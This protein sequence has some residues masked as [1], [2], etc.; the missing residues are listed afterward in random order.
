MHWYLEV[1]KKYA[2][3]SGR[4]RRREYWIFSLI[5]ILIGFLLGVIEGIAGIAPE[6]DE[7]ILALLYSLA[8][9]LPSLAVGVRRL[10]DIGKSGWWLL[11]G[12]VPLIG[13]IVLFIFFLR[14]SEPGTNR[15]GPNPKEGVDAYTLESA[16]SSS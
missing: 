10:H 13:A 1:L 3:F 16:P 5:N 7:S 14:D 6:S 4:A 8:V 9:L 11:I 12:L 15:F 2:V